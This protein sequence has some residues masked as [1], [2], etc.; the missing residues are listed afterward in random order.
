MGK[1]KTRVENMALIDADNHKKRSY[2]SVALDGFNA[3]FMEIHVVHHHV[4]KIGAGVV[5][6]GQVLLYVNATSQ[7]QCVRYMEN[8]LTVVFVYIARSLMLQLKAIVVLN[9]ENLLGARIAQCVNA[10]YSRSS[11]SSTA[12][13]DSARYANTSQSIRWVIRALDVLW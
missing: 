13:H 4:E 3:R 1:E 5:S 2:V 6:M 9:A 11:A 8:E 12:A 10:S 7:R